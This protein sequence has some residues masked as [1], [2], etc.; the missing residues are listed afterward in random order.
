MSK[1]EDLYYF[2][3]EG[4]IGFYESYRNFSHQ[5]I[6][7][8]KLALSTSTVHVN[9]SPTIYTVEKE[10]S[11]V[12]RSYVENVSP[13]LQEIS[14]EDVEAASRY[15][16]ACYIDGTEKHF[17]YDDR[18]Y[19]IFT[20]AKKYEKPVEPH[21]EN[22]GIAFVAPET[23]SKP[24]YPLR[25]SPYAVSMQNQPYAIN[26][27]IEIIPTETTCESENTTKIPV[28]EKATE[29][30]DPTPPLTKTDCQAKKERKKEIIESLKAWLVLLV[31][32]AV[33]W[34]IFYKIEND[35]D[36]TSDNTP[37]YSQIY[38]DGFLT[39]VAE[40]KSGTILSTTS[41]I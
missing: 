24:M 1:V 35:S 11:N 16:K 30:D 36:S 31:I 18:F 19:N 40:P 27:P 10:E 38:E 28:I 39:P 23:E 26:R 9:A 15:F 29:T 41:Q 6:T 37:N 3:Y 22:Q 7:Y 21:P 34:G 14:A 17:Q 20:I 13:F 25:E 4:K 5:E 32:I 12:I 2:N 33:L 8:I